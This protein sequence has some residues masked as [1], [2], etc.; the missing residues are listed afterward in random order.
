[1]DGNSVVLL[2]NTPCSERCSMYSHNVVICYIYASYT[3]HPE[4]YKLHACGT[5]RYY[6]LIH[7]HGNMH[8]YKV[9]HYVCDLQLSVH[10]R[11]YSGTH[12]TFPFKYYVD[13]VN[14]N[15][16]IQTQISMYANK[17]CPRCCM[18]LIPACTDQILTDVP[19]LYHG[20]DV[21]IKPFLNYVVHIHDKNRG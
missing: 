18:M 6:V 1:M 2:R 15:K 9:Q 21:L 16:N 12:G 5:I 11:R 8:V 14:H 19:G 4:S 13:V 3:R 20:L 17:P 10:S 7:M